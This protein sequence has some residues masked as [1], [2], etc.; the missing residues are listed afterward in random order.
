MG[1]RRAC[2]PEGGQLASVAAV[3]VNW[4]EA[5]LTRED[6]GRSRVEVVGDL[7]ADPMPERVHRLGSAVVGD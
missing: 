7:S 2:Y 4:S 1:G 6:R 3:G 5:G